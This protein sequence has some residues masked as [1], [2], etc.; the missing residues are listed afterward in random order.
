MQ[1]PRWRTPKQ[2]SYSDQRFFDFFAF[3]GILVVFAR[4]ATGVLHP[5][6]EV[7]FGRGDFGP[8]SSQVHWDGGQR[9]SS[10]ASTEHRLR[11]AS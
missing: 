3:F 2:G 7:V 5:M 6:V 11:R 1:S 8:G 4:P 10:S 9:P